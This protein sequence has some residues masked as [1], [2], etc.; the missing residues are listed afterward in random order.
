MNTHT[1]R[2]KKELRKR[3]DEIVGLN[4]ET[5]DIQSLYPATI[6]QIKKMPKSQP[7]VAVKKAYATI[8]NGFSGNH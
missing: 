6:K 4:G 3:K 2:I 7:A 5:M 8:L 1:E